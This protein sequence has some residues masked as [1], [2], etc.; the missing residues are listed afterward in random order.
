MEYSGVQT[1]NFDDSQLMVEEVEVEVVPAGSGHSEGYDSHGNYVITP[2][3]ELGDSRRALREKLRAMIKKKKNHLSFLDSSSEDEDD[4]MSMSPREIK[5]TQK[6]LGEASSSQIGFEKDLL[7]L[8]D[9]IRTKRQP[10]FLPSPPSGE[11]SSSGH[12]TKNTTPPKSLLDCMPANKKVKRALNEPEP[13]K[14]VP[15]H[16][17]DVVTKGS[18]LLP[19]SQGKPKQNIAYEFGNK[20]YRA[21]LGNNTIFKVKKSFVIHYSNINKNSRYY[22]KTFKHI[23]IFFFQINLVR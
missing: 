12:A 5:M 18:F 19:V 21:V 22:Q 2:V 17:Q 11:A 20:Q 14:L 10:N 1:Q 4:P 3:Q 9:K 7:E 13:E 16:D 6:G 23:N 15:V 8:V